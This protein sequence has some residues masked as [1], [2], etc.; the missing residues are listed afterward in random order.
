[1]L[2]LVVSIALAYASAPSNYDRRKYVK[3]VR[4]AALAKYSDKG[5]AVPTTSIVLLLRGRRPP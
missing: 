5:N 3:E 2:K 4:P 1:M